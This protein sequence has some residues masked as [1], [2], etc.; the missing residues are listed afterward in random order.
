MTACDPG[1]VKPSERTE[2]AGWRR[3][4]RE[5]ATEWRDDRV[6]GL[7]A[8]IAF[9]AILGLFPALLALAGALG[10]LDVIAGKDLAT[11]VEDA[12]I[13]A[14]QR[15][16]TDE[17]SELIRSVERLFAESNP[18]L[19]TVGLLTA[20]WTASRGFNAVIDALDNVYDLEEG[21]PYLRRRGLALTLAAGTVVV[22]AIVLGMLVVGPLFGTGADVAERFGLGGAFATFWDWARWPTVALAMVLWAATVFHLAPNHKTPWRWDLPGALVTAIF[23]AMVSVGLRVYL[24]V[25]PSADEVLGTAGG[26]LIALLWLYLLALGLL[27]GGEVN[28]MLAKHRGV[29]QVPRRTA[30]TVWTRR[31]GNGGARSRVPWVALPSGEA[32][33]VTDANDVVIERTFR[34]PAALLWQMWTEPEHFAAWY[35][36]TGATIPVARLDASVGGTRLVC[37]EMDTPN[38]P[39]QMWF[40]GEHLEAVESQRLVYTESMADADGNIKAAAEM[41][42]P[43]GHPTTTEVHVDLSEVD[44]TTTMVMTHVGVPADS[45]GAAGWSMAFDK[46]TAHLDASER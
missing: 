34:A 13:E 38:G 18:G 25:A 10:W 33:N 41:G 46:L 1:C 6:T 26:V 24:A 40:T 2:T 44:G 43:E 32:P 11:R 5:L 28:A 37:M 27:L 4:L 8:E 42:M 23:W 7:A 19:F 39:M 30:P 14:L 12:V 16:L 15:V 21:R 22:F 31:R 29:A 17:A 45:P 20:V 3:H 35:G 9:F 36:P